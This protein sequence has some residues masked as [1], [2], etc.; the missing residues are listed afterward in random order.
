MSVVCFDSLDLLF[1]STGNGS[2]RR[3]LL[4][5][6]GQHGHKDYLLLRLKSDET[7]LYS[8]VHLFPLPWPLLHSQRHSLLELGGRP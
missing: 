4:E 7:P 1:V 6:Q 2:Q 3:Y 8:I 5:A